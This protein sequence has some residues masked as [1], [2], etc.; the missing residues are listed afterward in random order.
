MVAEEAAPQLVVLSIDSGI[1]FPAAPGSLLRVRARLAAAW[2][3]S[4]AVPAGG[5]PHFGTE[6]AWE[7][8]VDQLR[9]LRRQR[10]VVR[11]EVWRDQGLVG[12]QLLDVRTAVAVPDSEQAATT[13]HKLKG[14]SVAEV[15]LGLGLALQPGPGRCP[16]P[17]LVE[18]TG[19]GYFRLGPEGAEGADRCRQLDCLTLLPP[20]AGSP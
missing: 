3:E 5:Q 19:G 15:R 7:V 2:L 16:S 6:L 4:A 17:V 20:A 18:G 9:E 14:C 11:V 12:H 1:G 8:G 13:L 10:A